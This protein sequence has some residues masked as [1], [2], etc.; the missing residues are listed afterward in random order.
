MLLE[1]R[2]FCS[3]KMKLL[4]YKIA[5][6]CHTDLYSCNDEGTYECQSLYNKHV[7]LCKSGYV[8]RRCE[9]GKTKFKNMKKSNLHYIRDITPKRV[10]NG[11]VHL[12]TA[13]TG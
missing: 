2:I 3:L 6:Q 8:G 9:S 5:A 12:P 11:G 7:C 1:L 13:V 4:Y 10:T